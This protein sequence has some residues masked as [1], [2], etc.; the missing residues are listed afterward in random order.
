MRYGEMVDL[1]NCMSIYEGRAE[2]K[3]RRRKMTFDEAIA[4]R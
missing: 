3:P 1:I 2:A 4:M